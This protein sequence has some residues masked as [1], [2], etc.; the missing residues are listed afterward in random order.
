MRRADI[1]VSAAKKRGRN[2]PAWFDTEMKRELHNRSS[3]EAGLRL[4]VPRGEIVPFYEQQIDLASGRLE[5]FEVLARWQHP[6]GGVVGPDRFIPVAEEAGLIGD[7][8]MSVMRQ[9]FEEARDWD[10]ALT[11]SV[12]ISPAQLKDPWLAQKIAKLL[13][14]T[15][16]PPA[17]LEVEITENALFANLGLAQSIIASLKNHGIRLA[18]D[19]FGTG[20]SSIAHLRALPFDR[21]KIDKSLVR[22]M[23]EDKE[24]AAIV[25]AITGLGDSLGIPVTAEGVES[26]A[27]E[28]RLR[29]IG[30][31][32]G[33][34]WHFGRPM[35]LVDTRKLLAT[36]QRPA[37]PWY[38]E[39][40]TPIRRPRKA[41]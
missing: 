28:E 9:A 26:A 3:V 8:S 14:E 27:I 40:V 21:I 32:R 13:A 25:A 6:S 12:N 15:G 33:Q 20:F 2:R 39:R 30:C 31:H 38:G 41:G 19:D 35:A 37:A 11:L 16:F 36:P 10:P 23:I 5:G 4:G 17:R 18:L 24:S 29:L 1:A 22:S 34:G 7:L